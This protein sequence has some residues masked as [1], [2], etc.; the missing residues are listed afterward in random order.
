MLEQVEGG[1]HISSVFR[2]LL[3]MQRRGELGVPYV[4]SH[5]VAAVSLDIY[6]I[7]IYMDLL[8]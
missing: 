8:D 2:E 6:L 7:S 4:V 3:V 5:E 1:H